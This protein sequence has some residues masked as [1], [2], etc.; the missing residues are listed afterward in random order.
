MQDRLEEMKLLI[1]IFHYDAFTD[2]P[3]MG[4][5]AGI[6]LD[7][8]NLSEAQMLAVAAAI[9]FNETAFI[10]P[11]DKA[12]FRLRFFTP[13][14]EMD[15]CGH[16]T[17]ASL[18]MMKERGFLGFGE[19]KLETRAGVLPI[20]ITEDGGRIIVGMQQAEY[21]EE[22]F[23]GSLKDLAGSIG[24]SEE[25]LDPRFPVVYGS[26]GIWTLLLPVK[27]LEKFRYM[28]PHNA[29][30]P[31]ILTPKPHSSI[32]PFC[33]QT[34]HPE[35]DMHG[36]HFSSPFSGTVEDPVTG[37]ASGVMGAYYQKYIRTSRENK[38]AILVEQGQEIGKD[39]T[40]LVELPTK[41]RNTVK[42]FGTAV[43]VEEFEVEI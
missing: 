38:D 43:F 37:T 8:G 22:R 33:L 1:N 17:I 3:G 10:M 28:N 29:R 13:G 21:Q 20:S 39:G 23:T 25:D 19:I 26:T 14:H 9:G 12:E 18:Y 40:I 11:S 32:H 34:I 6:V 36:R 15:L 7:A 24:L 5:P 41:Q 31:E 16:A 42:I 4:N 27:S 2:K 30:F 35:A